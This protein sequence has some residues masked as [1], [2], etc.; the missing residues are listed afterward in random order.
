MNPKLAEFLAGCRDEAPLQLGVIPFGMIYGIA[1]LAAGMPVWLAQAASAVLFA[2]ASQLV[3]VQMLGAGAGLLPMA[4]TASLL[5]VRHVLYSMSIAEYVR[6]L[7]RR[8]RLLLAYLL[9]DEAYAVAILRYQQTARPAPVHDSTGPA[10]SDPSSAF[11]APAT[12]G[13]A[14]PDLRHWY[15]LGCGFTLWACWQLST[16]AGI[17]FGATLPPEWDIDF[18][19]PLTFIALLTLLTRERAGRAAALMAGLAAL[20]LA[21]LPYKLGLV[22]AIVAGLFAG[23]WAARLKPT[24]D[25]KP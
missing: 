25:E 24:R 11:S 14:A 5:N 13:E 1:A 3:I 16:A 21:V 2:G 12:A 10:T 18:A 8:W 7:P 6:H 22:A 23:V 20:A 17:V 4:L 19:V 15:F 9:T